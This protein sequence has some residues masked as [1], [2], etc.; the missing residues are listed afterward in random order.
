MYRRQ[1]AL[2]WPVSAIWLAATSGGL[3]WLIS[4]HRGC[5]VTAQRIGAAALARWA[6]FMAASA[7]R[8]ARISLAQSLM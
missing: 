8:K 2:V 4:P 1:L 6:L 3:G 7:V 5:L